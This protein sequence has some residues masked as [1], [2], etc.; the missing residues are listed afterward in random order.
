MKDIRFDTLEDNLPRMGRFAEL[1]GIFDEAVFCTLFFEYL[2][3][4][5]VSLSEKD[6]F[7]YPPN[8]ETFVYVKNAF[9]DE[10]YDVFSQDFSDPRLKYAPSFKEAVKLVCGNIVSYC[11]LPIEERG[12]RL[13]TVEELIFRND[14][15]INSVIPVFG[16]DGN[17]DLKYALVSKNIYRADY[18]VDDDRYFEIRIPLDC[19]HGLS[20]L[21]ICSEELHVSIYRVNTLTFSTEDGEKS[22]FSVVL[23]SLGGDFALLLVYLTL[24]L[25]DYI[26]VGIYKNLE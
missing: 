3:N 25:S 2:K 26:P 21:A 9:A 18:F 6:F 22:Y 8:D 16:F 4:H 14:C 11:L 13:P 24:F 17:A 7:A 15:K 10:A 19:E 23:K 12:V 20:R 5:G 1:A